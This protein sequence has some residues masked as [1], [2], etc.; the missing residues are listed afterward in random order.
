MSYFLSIS[1]GVLAL[2]GSC[3]NVR[4]ASDRQTIGDELTIRLERKGC[5][6]QCP[7]YIL[8]IQPD[9]SVKF[10]GKGYTKTI[11]A[12]ESKIGHDQLK[13][14][15]SA[16]RK[17]D[18]FAFR[19]TYE[20]GVD[21]C[22]RTATDMPTVILSVRLDNREK[23]I[24]HYH[25]CLELSEPQLVEP[26]KVARA[27]NLQPFPRKLTTLEDRIDEIV[28]TKQWTGDGSE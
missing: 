28:S 20:T 13:E 5:Y 17:N 18:F 14:L 19:D 21:G 25:G 15:I 6:G 22:P 27:E 26:G 16:I 12:V 1:L 24:L 8:D 2:F 11:G 10:E 3:G 9:G 7:M 4:D 23:T